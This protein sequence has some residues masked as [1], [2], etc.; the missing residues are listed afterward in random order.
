MEL[1]TNVQSIIKNAILDV[2]NKLNQDD[3]LKAIEGEQ[4]LEFY[5]DD[6]MVYDRKVDGAQDVVSSYL[7]YYEKYLNGIL[8]EAN[9]DSFDYFM[10]NEACIKVYY[11]PSGVLN[12][13]SKFR[14]FDKKIIKFHNF[15]LDA[16]VYDKNKREKELSEYLSSKR[17]TVEQRRYIKEMFKESRVYTRDINSVME[18]IQEEILDAMNEINLK[19]LIY[20]L[21]YTISDL[22]VYDLSEDILKLIDDSNEVY[23]L[24]KEFVSVKKI[25]SGYVV[26]FSEEVIKEI[27]YKIELSFE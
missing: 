7:A 20:Y 10:K 6:S 19:D 12:I 18:G 21:G 15:E 5:A 25:E 26:M 17:F 14:I 4:V 16:F 1:E 23:S 22:I 13:N 11:S 27:K 9:A 3:N 8:N 2:K 24:F